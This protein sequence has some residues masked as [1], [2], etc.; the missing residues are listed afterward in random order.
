MRLGEVRAAE[1]EDRENA[2]SSSRGSAFPHRERALSSTL[3]PPLERV[4]ALLSSQSK[5]VKG[6]SQRTRSV[7]QSEAA[8]QGAP[9][10]SSSAGSGT[11]PARS[12]ADDAGCCWWLGWLGARAAGGREAEVGCARESAC[13]VSCERVWAASRTLRERSELEDLGKSSPKMV[14]RS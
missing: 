14:G 8:E 12:A 5:D 3:L 2:R 1:G 13:D 4:A 9:M 7:L 11:M 10:D 6:L